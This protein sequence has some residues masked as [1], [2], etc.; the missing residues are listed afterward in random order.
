MLDPSLLVGGKLRPRL[1]SFELKLSVLGGFYFEY[2]LFHE[3]GG[4]ERPQHNG[5]RCVGVSIEE[6]CSQPLKINCP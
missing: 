2:A 5:D 6:K 1:R 3:D 4:E